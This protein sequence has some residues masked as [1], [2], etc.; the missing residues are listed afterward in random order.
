MAY[1]DLNKCSQNIKESILTL[2]VGLSVLFSCVGNFP[3]NAKGFSFMQ[4]CMMS[5]YIHQDARQFLC[6]PQ[7]VTSNK[8]T[9]L[10][11]TQL[12]HLM[13]VHANVDSMHFGN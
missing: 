10:F 2:I 12:N 4:L 13:G 1:K 3:W 8:T 6:I 5:S 9:L 7:I 11:Q